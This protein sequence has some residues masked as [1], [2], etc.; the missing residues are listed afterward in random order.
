VD[1]QHFWRIGFKLYN[2]NG[3]VM[4]KQ[5]EGIKPGIY[6]NLSSEEYHA[7]SAISS[8][9]IK[10]LLQNP[11]KFWDTRINPER[12]QVDTKA[13]KAGKAFHTLL[14]EPEKFSQQ[15]IV[16]PP[17]NSIKIDS[18]IWEKL[19]CTPD[20]KDFEL[21]TTKTAKVVHYVGPKL[22]VS[23]ED[24]RD[25]QMAVAE[26]RKSQYLSSL[27]KGG[28]I[29]VSLFW[30]DELSGLMCR[31][32][33][34]Y[35][36]PLWGI[37]YKTTT[38]VTDKTALGWSIADYFYDASGAMYLE[39]MKR[40][41]EQGL[42][43]H[44]NHENFILLFQE[45]KRPYIARAVRLHDE[46]LSLGYAKFRRGLEIYQQNIE[47]YGMAK[48]SAGYDLV[49]DMTMDDMPYKYKQ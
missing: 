33:F 10:L 15:F 34:D 3:A 25:M 5:P 18:E 8:S 7:D 17:V 14:L 47:Q 16:L 46:L 42:Y 40:L 23:E 36:H 6:F 9:G 11:L 2:C 45:K 44:G 26:I 28:L 32:R 49:E 41:Y 31:V 4:N 30:R 22:V 38:D 29:E 27:C 37:D 20:G 12:E 43:E 35:L 19:S 1:I 48:W 21:P 24:Y 39:G 13:L